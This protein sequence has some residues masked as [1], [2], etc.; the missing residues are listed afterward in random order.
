MS[1]VCMCNKSYII[2]S[3][4]PVVVCDTTGLTKNTDVE[5]IDTTSG[6]PIKFDVVVEDWI[7]N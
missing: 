7:N 6:V 1:S 3:Y 2:E 4:E 5:K